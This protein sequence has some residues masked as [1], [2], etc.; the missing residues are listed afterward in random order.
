MNTTELLL[1][2]VR[3]SEVD[4]QKRILTALIDDMN[5]QAFLETLKKGLSPIHLTMLKGMA[6]SKVKR[7]ERVDSGFSVFNLHRNNAGAR[8]DAEFI[9][10]F[11][12][13]AFDKHIKPLHEE[14]IMLIFKKPP[15]KY[16]GPWVALCTAY[17][18]EDAKEVRNANK[19]AA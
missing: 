7:G 15:T 16:T 5:G 4:V 17:V 6:D 19:K 14:G 11:G 13:E 18:N 10:Q 1:D 12:Q 9:A 2:L 3:K 8:A